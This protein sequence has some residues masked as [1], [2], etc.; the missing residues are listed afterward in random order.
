[1]TLRIF[2]LDGRP[3]LEKSF[4]RGTPG[5]ST[6]ENSFS[7]DGRNGRGDVVASGGYIVL[8]EA[9]GQG[10]TLNVIRRKIGVVR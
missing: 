8:I 1:V 9:Q 2:A 4:A 6:G 5:G 10:S 7:W 3:V